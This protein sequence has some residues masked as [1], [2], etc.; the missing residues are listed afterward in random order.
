MN[1]QAV[2]TIVCVPSSKHSK[3]PPAA[4]LVIPALPNKDW[5]KA[6]EELRAGRKPGKKRDMYLPEKGGGMR[7]RE[8]NATPISEAEVDAINTEEVVGGLEKME[9]KVKMEVD[10]SSIESQPK[11][12]MPPPPI[13]VKTEETEERRALRELLGEGAS[14]GEAEEP[15]VDAIYSAEDARNGPIEEADAFKRDVDSRPDEVRFMSLTSNPELWTNGFSFRQASLD[16]YARVP[17]GAFG[18]AMLRGMG[19]QP[20]QAASRSGRGAIEAHVPSS[21]PSL[22][23]IGAK[24]MAEAMGDDGKKEAK[25]KNGSGGKSRRE[26]MKFV[27]LVKQAREGST[28]GRSV[29]S[30]FLSL[31]KKFHS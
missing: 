9:R 4:P 8:G 21:R 29:S 28:S 10:E 7:M 17:V 12:E 6:A 3:P 2:L 1:S 22:L 26:D 23:G 11:I 20:G 30:P 5:R 15:K 27:P 31:S 16:D 25:G 24:P 13:P 19:W 18:L 14:A